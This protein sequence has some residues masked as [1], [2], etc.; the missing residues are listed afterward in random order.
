MLGEEKKMCYFYTRPFH[1]KR[2]VGGARCAQ[3]GLVPIATM[4][5]RKSYFRLGGKRTVNR[6]LP[7]RRRP[8]TSSRAR[9]PMTPTPLPPRSSPTI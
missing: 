3:P 8:R 6:L 7:D 9:Q 4:F 1:N 5:Y 2:M